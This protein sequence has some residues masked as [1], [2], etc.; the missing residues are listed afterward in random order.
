MTPQA[1]K[2]YK[3]LSDR[4]QIERVALNEIALIEKNTNL[5]IKFDYGVTVAPSNFKASAF[6]VKFS[7]PVYYN[8]VVWDYYWATGLL[9]SSVGH[10]MGHMILNVGDDKD[11]LVDRF[12]YCYGST[13]S[14]DYLTDIK[15]ID[16]AFSCN[17]IYKR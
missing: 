3:P 7:K 17:D 8:I 13:S 2:D 14:K 16:L 5:D 4:K 12:A 11:W 6:L 10:E 15:N 9:T 1:V